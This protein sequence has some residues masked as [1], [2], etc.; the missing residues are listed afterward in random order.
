MGE[1]FLDNLVMETTNMMESAIRS[2]E[3]L[4][5]YDSKDEVV[6]LKMHGSIY[7]LD[8]TLYRQL[9]EKTNCE[10]SDIDGLCSQQLMT[11]APDINWTDAKIF[12]ESRSDNDRI[13]KQYSI[14]GI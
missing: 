14:E 1:D 5:V 12:E 9:E 13:R 7:W 11:E 10:N 4:L 3:L 8:R 2:C 6:V